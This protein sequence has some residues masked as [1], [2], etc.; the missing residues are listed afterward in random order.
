MGSSKKASS[1]FV[2]TDVSAVSV[3]FVGDSD[4]D[5]LRFP[6]VCPVPLFVHL[7]PLLLLL[8]LFLPVR[9]KT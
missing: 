7:L 5:R 9:G 2:V 3:A 4:F 6:V 1:S 8:L